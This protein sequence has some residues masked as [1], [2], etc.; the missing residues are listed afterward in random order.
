MNDM[1]P[2]VRMGVLGYDLH[3]SREDDNDQPEP[4]T[5]ATLAV[6]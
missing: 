1:S 3:T 5:Q 6:R 2:S 4:D